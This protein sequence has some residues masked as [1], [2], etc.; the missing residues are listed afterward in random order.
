[1][2]YIVDKL[3]EVGLTALQSKVY[4]SI[5]E[6]GNA[7]AGEI[8]I[9]AKIN[10]VTTYTAL[11]ELAEMSL[12]KVN[13]RDAVKIYQISEFDNLSVEFMRRAKMAIK[14]YQIVH[15]LVPDL[16][17]MNCHQSTDPDIRYY[18]GINAI[19]YLLKKHTEDI[20]DMMYISTQ[21]HYVLL[22]AVINKAAADGNRPRVIIPN[23]VKAELIVY[24]DHR[25]VPAK[26]AH[27]PT[28]TIILKDKYITLYGDAEFPQA[29]LTDDIR[30][31]KQQQSIFELNWRILSGEHIIVPK[32]E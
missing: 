25:V 2:R 10:R 1:M 18:E 21:E 14:S 11:H 3:I 32:A 17:T 31:T 13:E 20:I 5:I 8:A 29:Y 4:V 19:N 16:K 9:K 15:A 24:L 30:L 6:L 7:T 23:S 12:I 28:S 26:I 22:K 27:F